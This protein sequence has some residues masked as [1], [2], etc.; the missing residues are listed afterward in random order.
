MDAPE[1][2]GERRFLW[3]AEFYSAPTP[4]TVLPAWAIRGCGAAAVLV[5]L[6]LFAGGAFLA[7]GGFVDLMDLVLGM[8]VGEMKGMY[9]ADVNAARKTSLER[10]V[11]RL[12]GNLRDG[13][14][15]VAGLQPFLEELRRAT[16]DSKVTAEEAE[17]LRS[18]ARSI[19]T[20]PP[21]PRR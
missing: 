12:R 10:E 5:L 11:D 6:L 4:Q 13:R 14:V 18:A 7:S 15:S 19:N 9:G 2:S 3:P 21:P 16:G 20:A 8:S 1:S 17:R